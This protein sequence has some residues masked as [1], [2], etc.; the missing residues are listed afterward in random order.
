MPTNWLDFV[1]A[2][3]PKH[4][5]EDMNNIHSMKYWQNSHLPQ[6]GIKK[7]RRPKVT[8]LCPKKFSPPSKG[9]FATKKSP[10]LMQG[11][12]LMCMQAVPPPQE[13]AF[14]SQLSFD[15]FMDF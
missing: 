13:M 14:P 1:M 2:K 12:L 7:C 5:A 9:A 3:G 10:K 4:V 15:I 11:V 6:L 8:I